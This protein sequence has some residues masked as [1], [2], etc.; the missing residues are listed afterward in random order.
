[1]QEFKRLNPGI[2]KFSKKVLIKNVPCKKLLK[3]TKTVGTGTV[4]IF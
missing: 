3:K 1:M 2:L 4:Y